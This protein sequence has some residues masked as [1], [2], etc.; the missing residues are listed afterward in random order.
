MTKKGHEKVMELLEQL[1]QKKVNQGNCTFT[2]GM[3]CG[4]LSIQPNQEVVKKRIAYF[5][6]ASKEDNFISYFYDAKEFI[7]EYLRY[8]ETGELTQFYKDYDSCYSFRGRQ[9]VPITKEQREEYDS[10]PMLE[11]DHCGINRNFIDHPKYTW[12]I[13]GVYTDGY[14]SRSE[15]IVVDRKLKLRRAETMGEYYQGGKV[16]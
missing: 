13:V 8:F 3:I 12:E 2:I 14:C 11:Y 5:L 16:D 7:D 1:Y 6:K 15:R 4:V 9:T 10:Y